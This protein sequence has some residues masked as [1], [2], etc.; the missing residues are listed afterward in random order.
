MEWILCVCVCCVLLK[1]IKYALRV[2]RRVSEIVI[3]SSLWI[4]D[5]NLF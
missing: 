2:E 3:K 4:V 1:I 5:H